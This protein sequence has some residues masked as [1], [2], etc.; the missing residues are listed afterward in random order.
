MSK[1]NPFWKENVPIWTDKAVLHD[2]FVEAHE[3]L[4]SDKFEARLV[5]ARARLGTAIA[6]ND[7]GQTRELCREL[8]AIYT[9][10]LYDTC[11]LLAALA[12]HLACKPLTHETLL[13]DAIEAAQLAAL[14]AEDQANPTPQDDRGDVFGPLA[15]T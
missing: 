9:E 8:E 1:E 4:I 10:I 13:T 5:S 2:L 15:Y 11:R 14:V 6:Q 12:P 7:C 3:R